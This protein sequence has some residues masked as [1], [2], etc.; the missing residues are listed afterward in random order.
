MEN[1]Q[2]NNGN[3]IHDLI[4]ILIEYN[5]KYNFSFDKHLTNDIETCIHFLLKMMLPVKEEN[6]IKKIYIQTMKNKI[7]LIIEKS[8]KL[9]KIIDDYDNPNHELMIEKL[10]NMNRLF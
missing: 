9:D 7:K 1:I 6:K 8:I 4:R 5:L 2:F 3:D 10:K